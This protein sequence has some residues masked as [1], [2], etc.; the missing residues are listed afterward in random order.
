MESLKKTQALITEWAINNTLQ[1]NGS[2]IKK[3]LFTTINLNS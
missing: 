1:Y 3:G 2:R